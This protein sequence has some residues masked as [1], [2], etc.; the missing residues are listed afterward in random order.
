[1][2]TIRPVPDQVI[3]FP[4][5]DSHPAVAQKQTFLVKLFPHPG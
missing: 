5:S 4:P 3:L 2:L 1:V